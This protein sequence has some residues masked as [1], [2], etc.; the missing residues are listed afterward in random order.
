MLL[1]FLR[2]HQARIRLREFN[3]KCFGNNLHS[4]GK[5]TQL[6]L[7]GDALNQRG[8]WQL[9]VTSAP[10]VPHGRPRAQR[11]TA[12]HR[13]H[14]R[15]F[16]VAYHGERRGNRGGT[17]PACEP[18]FGVELEVGIGGGGPCAATGFATMS[19]GD[20]EVVPTK[21]TRT[22]ALRIR[23]MARVRLLLIS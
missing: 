23:L 17:V 18:D 20:L 19:L 14:P 7:G 13:P 11:R 3:L 1:Q 5:S 16:R 21:G 4:A 2:R 22:S 12:L 6:F 8:R 9:L 15:P 10:I